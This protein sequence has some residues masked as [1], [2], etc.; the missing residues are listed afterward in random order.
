MKNKKLSFFSDSED[1]EKCPEIIL[2][3]SQVVHGYGDTHARL[4]FVVMAPGRNGADITGVPFTKDPSG[5]LFQ[6]C[7]IRAG[8][9]HETNPRYEHPRLNDVYVTNLV[10][11]NPK[12]VTGNNRTPSLEEIKNCST[13]FE[14]EINDINPELVVLFGK[15][16][17]EHIIQKK[18]S[19]FSDYHN[20][21]VN[22]HNRIF[23]PFIHPSYVIRGA[24]NR[25]KYI[26]ELAGLKTLLNKR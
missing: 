21:P 15:V 8:F 6:E 9:S 5:V 14:K 20:K 4:M 26:E 23:L 25:Q 19:K 22:I 11:C 1:C 17:T 3:R 18:I 12:D 10:K 16:V 24:Y 2:S 13:H 7:L